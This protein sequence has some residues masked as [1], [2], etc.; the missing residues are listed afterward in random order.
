[1]AK[2]IKYKLEVL[3]GYLA[4]FRGELSWQWKK[5]RKV[6]ESGVIFLTA[7][8]DPGISEVFM[9]FSV[10]K[11]QFGVWQ[12]LLKESRTIYTSISASTRNI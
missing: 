9:D 12:L 11:S 5:H 1:M 7:S 10:T 3:G 8:L 6:R 4:T 2:E